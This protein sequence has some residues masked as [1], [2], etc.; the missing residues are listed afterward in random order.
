MSKKTKTKSK[1]NIKVI[2]YAV[3]ILLAVIS[4]CT[5]FTEVCGIKNGDDTSYI[6]TGIQATFGYS[7]QTTV[8]GSVVTSTYTVFSFMNLLIY[9]LL[10]A[11]IILAVLKA[12]NIIQ[13]GVID[14][15]V[16]VLFIVA[17]ILYFIMPN[18]VVY[19][20]AWEDLVALAVKADCIKTIL[21]GGVVGGASSI[22]AG[23]TIV[24]SKFVKK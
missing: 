20:S 18:F 10:V 4:F 23:G 22:V 24:V 8:L 21:V 16:A 17:G 11:G 3:A 7:K 14:W 15:T 2:L 12:F 13:S 9:I 19:G 5:I 1:L 6:L